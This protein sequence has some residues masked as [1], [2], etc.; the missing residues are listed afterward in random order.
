M[1]LAGFTLV[2][3]GIDGKIANVRQMILVEINVHG[4]TL[5]TPRFVNGMGK[6]VLSQVVDVQIDK[7]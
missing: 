3:L 7:E 6:T 4:G 2:F 5:L 1:T